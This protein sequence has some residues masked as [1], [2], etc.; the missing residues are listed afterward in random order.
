MVEHSPLILTD[1]PEATRSLS[2]G[3]FQTASEVPENAMIHSVISWQPIVDHPP[4]SSQR[5]FDPRQIAI[6]AGGF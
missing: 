2:S 5:Q 1:R 3:I 6:L 4:G